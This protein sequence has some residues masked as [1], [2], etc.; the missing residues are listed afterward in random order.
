MVSGK[1]GDRAEKVGRDLRTDEL[2]LGVP[3]TR[4]SQPPFSFH[5]F[6]PGQGGIRVSS[7]RGQWGSHFPSWEGEWKKGPLQSRVD[8]LPRGRQVSWGYTIPL[9]L[10]GGNVTGVGKVRG[11]ESI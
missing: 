3:Q 4:G 8:G 7:V 5:R 2:R 11:L 1:Q 10:R 9:W 6:L